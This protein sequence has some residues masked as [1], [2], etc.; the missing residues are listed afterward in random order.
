MKFSTKIIGWYDKNKRDLPWRKTNDPY[1]IWISEIILQQTRIDQGTDYYLRF[2]ERFPDIQALAT[3][4]EEDVLK[5]WQGLGYYSRARN[6]HHTA[7]TI[8]KTYNGIFPSDFTELISLKG[9]G[10]YSASAIASMAFGKPFAVVDGNVIRVIT[11]IFGIL[12]AVDKA[13]VKLLIKQKANELLDKKTPGIFNQAMMEFGA[14]FCKPANP[15]CPNCLFSSHCFAFKNGLIEKIPLIPKKNKLKK[16][17][18]YYLVF[19]IKKQGSIFSLISKREKN[20]I[21]KGLYDFPHYEF[22]SRQTN[23]LIKKHISNDCK[24]NAYRIVNMSNEYQHILSHQLLKARFI[25]LESNIDQPFVINSSID[26]AKLI[27]ISDDK[28]HDIPIPRLIEK[29]IT[30][31]SIFG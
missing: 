27:L 4:S 26:H 7:R 21:W 11:R 5:S 25:L 19:R 18:L 12:Q 14:L 1:K 20:D 9:I 23:A 31:N 17:Y 22:S 24:T 6:L 30:E 29:F 2:I 13:S 10:E 28:F 8:E 16:R 15:D 3:A